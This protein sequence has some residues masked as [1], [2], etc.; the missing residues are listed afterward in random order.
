MSMLLAEELV[1]LCMDDETGRCLL[2]EPDATQGVARALV[3]ELALRDTVRSVGNRLERDKKITIRDELLALACE[4][5]DGYRVEDAIQRLAAEDLLAA[6]L[7]R[8]VARGILHDA[9]VFA[10]G[11]HLP[12]EPQHEA[13]VRERLELVL[14]RD[15]DPSEHDATLIALLEPLTLTTQLFPD[16]EPAALRERAKKIAQRTRPLRSG[17]TSRGSW[18]DAMDLLE[19]LAIPLRILN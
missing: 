15:Q 19:I 5:V 11:R 17:H 18:W 1:L 4:R 8:L 7:A 13:R 6:L 10:P 16:A 14:V 9:E 3:F 2:P 12:R